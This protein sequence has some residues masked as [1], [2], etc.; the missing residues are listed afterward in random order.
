MISTHLCCRAIFHDE[1]RY[2]E[3]DTFNPNRFLTADGKLD[4]N[5]PDPIEAFGYSR[6]ICPGRYFAI[7]VVFLTIASILATF[8]I[9]KATDDQG[10]VHEPK[11][12]YSP[13]LFR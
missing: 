2:P 8:N 6:R 11:A 4:P 7:D 12:E 13:G 10:N 5:V 1:E 3:P 9:E